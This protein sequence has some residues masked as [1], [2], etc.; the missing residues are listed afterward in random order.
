MV[1][2][3]NFLDTLLATVNSFDSRRIKLKIGDSTNNRR[4]LTISQ[5]VR[6]LRATRRTALATQLETVYE[7][8]LPILRRQREVNNFRTDAFDFNEFINTYKIFII[9]GTA[10][11][12]RKIT[13]ALNSTTRFTA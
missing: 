13:T 2:S 7:L 10:N 4:T 1:N 11:N 12:K 8:L 5:V 6:F 3:T 9:N